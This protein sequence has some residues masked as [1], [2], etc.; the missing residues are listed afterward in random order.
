MAE[1]EHERED[2]IA[3]ATALVQRVELS[4]EGFTDFLVIGF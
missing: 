2:L 1:Y 4:I 3:T